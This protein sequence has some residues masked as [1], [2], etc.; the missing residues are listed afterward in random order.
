MSS[1]TPCGGRRAWTL[2]I[3]C[4]ER[5]ARAERFFSAASNATAIVVKIAQ[6]RG[7]SMFSP[8][9]KSS[10]APNGKLRAF[11]SA[12]GPSFTPTSHPDVIST[13]M[14][15]LCVD[16]AEMYASVRAAKNVVGTC[17]LI[18]LDFEAGP[19][20][21]GTLYGLTSFTQFECR[22]RNG[23][24]AIVPKGFAAGG[25]FN[26]CRAIEI[27]DERP[28]ELRVL[29]AARMID[30]GES[31]A[32]YADAHSRAADGR[33]QRPHPHRQAGSPPAYWGA[34]AIPPAP[35]H[36]YS[37][38]R[39]ASKGQSPAPEQSGSM[40]CGSRSCGSPRANGWRRPVRAGRMMPWAAHLSDGPSILRLRSG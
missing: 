8:A 37:V 16:K 23:I 35:P 34:A 15:V 13:F 25:S 38:R 4:P 21:S 24:L 20:H 7:S 26:G 1:T 9:R 2:S 6:R 28:P 27:I 11:S 22:C 12:N 5:S 18:L 32:S 29:S 30:S 40:T 39:A 31:P 33:F 3:H 19:L 36:P 10:A 14:V 17:S